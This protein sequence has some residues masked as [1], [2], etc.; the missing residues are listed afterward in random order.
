MEINHYCGVFP[1][2]LLILNAT[3]SHLI[4]SL[5]TEASGKC[6]G[7]TG[8]EPGHN[9]PS[10]RAPAL[11]L[12]LKP[13]DCSVLDSKQRQR[14]ISCLVDNKLFPQKAYFTVENNK[15]K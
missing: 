8:T 2:I 3:Q 6:Q 15:T 1:G 12:P 13:A 5:S 4:S 9:N 7:V 14:R 10:L 11:S